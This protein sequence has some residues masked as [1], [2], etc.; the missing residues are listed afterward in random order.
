MITWK[1]TINE[2]VD[3][4]YIHL[5]QHNPRL[6]FIYLYTNYRDKQIF[7]SSQILVND[8]CT[9]VIVCHYNVFWMMLCPMLYFCIFAHSNLHKWR[10]PFE[11]TINHLNDKDMLLVFIEM[12]IIHENFVYL[13]YNLLI[14]FANFFITVY[15]TLSSFWQQIRYFHQLK[16]PRCW[17]IYDYQKVCWQSIAVLIK[18]PN[19]ATKIWQL[20]DKINCVLLFYLCT[21]NWM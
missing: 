20:M 13:W 4:L 18:I 5:L 16:R 6:C 17:Q 7:P 9:K 19:D 10:F 14:Y 12:N 3:K 1:R 15:E 2:F 11:L 21:L 8:L